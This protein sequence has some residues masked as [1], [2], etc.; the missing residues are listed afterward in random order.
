MKLDK[1]DERAHCVACSIMLRPML[2]TSPT[3]SCSALAP[4]ADH[5]LTSAHGHSLA[6]SMISAQLLL[7]SYS[8]LGL[9]E[10]LAP[11]TNQS[12]RT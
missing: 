5:K 9:F 8:S 7:Q 3:R 11:C 1:A 4:P 10:T 2:S 12:P 6:T